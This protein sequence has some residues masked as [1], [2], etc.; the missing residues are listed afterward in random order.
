M[1]PDSQE[2]E[3]QAVARHLTQAL[4]TNLGSPEITA[5]ALSH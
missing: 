1:V 4:D 3:L 2:L 5:R